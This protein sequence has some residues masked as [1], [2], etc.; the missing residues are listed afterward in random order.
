MVSQGVNLIN[1]TLGILLLGFNQ[2]IQSIFKSFN[3]SDFLG[4]FLNVLFMA[5]LSILQFLEFLSVLFHFL[6]HLQNFLLQS[7]NFF[8]RIS[9]FDSLFYFLS[10][11]FFSSTGRSVS[12]FLLLG[13]IFL[14]SGFIQTFDSILLIQL[15]KF[16]LDIP[17]NFFE[18][19]NFFV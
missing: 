6:F 9:L 19:L 8:I 16:F 3:I 10:L 14:L 2:V 4:V 12:W 13:W 1:N 11:L 5:T 15:D 7:L 18:F 17:I